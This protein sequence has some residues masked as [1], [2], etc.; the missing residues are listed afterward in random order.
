MNL[1][2]I[3]AGKQIYP[4]TSVKNIIRRLKFFIRAKRNEKTLEHFI[5]A[6]NQQGN[7]SV[8]EHQPHVLGAVEWPYIHKNWTVEER[9]DAMLQHYALI[10][11]QSKFLQNINQQSNKILDLHEYS[12]NAYLVLDRP[13]WFAREGEIV[14]SLFKENHRIKSIAFTLAKVNDDLIIYIGAIQGITAG[15][16]SL[17]MFKTI[18]KDLE[19][20]RPKSFIIEVVRILANKMGVKKILAIS[21]ANRHHHHAYFRGS[22]NKMLIS[23]YDD[24]WAD[25]QGEQVIDGFYLIPVEEHRRNIVDISSNKRAMYRRRYQMLEQIKQSISTLN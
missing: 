19:G 4:I 12:P 9:F 24:T 23:N 5:H 15:D 21:D 6:I 10:K 11:T 13:T 1:E 25:H 8:L 18:T 16:D 14:L 20:L 2:I 22:L 3:K 17:T 7:A